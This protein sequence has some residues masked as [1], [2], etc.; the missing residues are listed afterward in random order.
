MKNSSVIKIFL[1]LLSVLLLSVASLGQWTSLGD[2]KTIS[3]TSGGLYA[4]NVYDPELANSITSL[5]DFVDRA[6]AEI[7]ISDQSD[8]AKMK[9]LFDLV[10]ERLKHK[11][12]NHTFFSNWI[13]FTLGQIHS[14]FLHVWDPD[15]LLAHGDVAYCDQS[16]YLLLTLAQ[17]FNVPSRH[18]GLYGHVVMEAWYEDD[19][20]LYDPDLEVIPEIEGEVLSVN[21]LISSPEVLQEFYGHDDHVME[22]FLSKENNTFVSYPVGARFEWKANVLAILERV[23]EVLEFI[24]PIVVLFSLLVFKKKQS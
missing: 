22:I 15:V 1:G 5:D 23:S 3:G 2:F 6:S 10:I 20:H 12:A 11:E 8:A 4:T 16:S 7:E 18:V 19:W 24:V 21:E 14:V 9:I 13:L 17:H